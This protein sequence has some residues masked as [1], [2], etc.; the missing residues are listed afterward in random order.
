MLLD[1]QHIVSTEEETQELL[2]DISQ[3]NLLNIF[4]IYHTRYRI[5]GGSIC[6][7]SYDRKINNK[8]VFKIPVT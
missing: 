6:F 1:H 3:F 8:I 7:K 2:L 4:Y 5:D